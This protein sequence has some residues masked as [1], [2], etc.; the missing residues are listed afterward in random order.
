MTDNSPSIHEMERLLEQAVVNYA[1]VHTTKGEDAAEPFL[2]RLNDMI[3]DRAVP[4]VLKQRARRNI[5][6]LGF[7]KE[8]NVMELLEEE[9][10]K[11]AVLERVTDLLL[12]PQDFASLI[13]MCEQFASEDHS[14]EGNLLSDV[15]VKLREKPILDSADDTTEETATVAETA[16]RL[17]ALELTVLDELFEEVTWPDASQS[18]QWYHMNALSIKIKQGLTSIR[19][20]IMSELMDARRRRMQIEFGE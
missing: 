12:I 3:E 13:A 10:K 8:K 9:L 6:S 2:Q 16:I 7:Q 1:H 17:T 14:Q 18:K 20:D 4:E 15:A 11:P 19:S 5:R